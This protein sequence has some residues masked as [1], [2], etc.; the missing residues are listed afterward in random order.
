MSDYKLKLPPVDEKRLHRYCK[1]IVDNC[2]EDR[3]L[4]LDA[5]NYFKDKVDEN[6]ADNVSKTLMATCLKLV[7][8]SSANYTKL[9]ETL[10]KMISKPGK[11][12]GDQ[13]SLENLWET[14]K[15]K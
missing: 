11:G 8:T 2:K 9:V 12:N 5:Y 15:K 4:A 1:D 6:P 7:Q 13:L 14:F 10:G 3:K